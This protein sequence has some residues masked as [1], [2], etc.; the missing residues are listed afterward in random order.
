MINIDY[1]ELWHATCKNDEVEIR[2]YSGPHDHREHVLIC[3]SE[4]HW[5]VLLLQHLRDYMDSKYGQN[6]H[7]YQDIALT[8]KHEVA[9]KCVSY[10]CDTVKVGH[11]LV[12]LSFTCIRH[13]VDD[14]IVVP[15]IDILC[16]ICLVPV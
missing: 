15:C 12:T 8:R 2:K 7:K 11:Q 5:N 9:F 13:I 4:Q 10:G 1:T 6:E 14:V 3:L 16:S